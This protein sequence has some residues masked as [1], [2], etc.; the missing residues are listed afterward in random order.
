MK[1]AFISREKV[2]FPVVVRISLNVTTW[3]TRRDHPSTWHDRDREFRRI[4]LSLQSPVGN[5]RVV[6]DYDLG[7]HAILI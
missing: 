6:T 4:P 7:G 5:L 2:A 3:I 1:F